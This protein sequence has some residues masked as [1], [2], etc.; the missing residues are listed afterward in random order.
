MFQN[1]NMYIFK[2]AHKKSQVSS[3]IKK[4]SQVPE[5]IQDWQIVT[6]FHLMGTYKTYDF[7]ND[8]S[9]DD[10]EQTRS[11][12]DQEINRPQCLNKCCTSD[13]Y[14]EK[15]KLWKGRWSTEDK[16][17]EKHWSVRNF[18]GTFNQFEPVQAC[19]LFVS[20]QEKWS[21]NHFVPEEGI[22]WA[23]EHIGLLLFF[24]L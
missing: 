2:L 3:E 14:K 22:S 8:E 24:D 6:R 17:K 5:G 11:F 16:F 20:V 7:I 9:G 13:M 10:D 23:L 19:G 18:S 21:G 12:E 1:I 15:L 4:K